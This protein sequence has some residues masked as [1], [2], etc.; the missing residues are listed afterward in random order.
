MTPG[1]KGCTYDEGC[2]PPISPYDETLDV[3]SDMQKVVALKFGPY[4]PAFGGKAMYAATRGHKKGA[5]GKQGIFRIWYDAPKFG[6]DAVSGPVRLPPKAVA[7][8]DAIIGFPPMTVNFNGMGSYDPNVV[9]QVASD[10]SYSSSGLQYKWDFGSGG[11]SQAYT[12]KASYRYE[13]AG[14]Y[15]AK[16]TVIDS[17]GKK[18]ST[19]IKIVVENIPPRLKIIEPAEDTTFSVGDVLKLR[20]SAT[21]FDEKKKISDDNLL[22]EVRLHHR[23][24]FHTMLEPTRG[25]KI[26]LPPAPEPSNFATAQESYLVVLLTARD[27]NG[28]SA[29][30]ETIIR[31]KL[32]EFTLNTNP[33]GMMLM[34]NSETFKTPITLSTWNKNKVK[35][36]TEQTQSNGVEKFEF[37][38]WSDGYLERD[39]TFVAKVGKKEE[40]TMVANYLGGLRIDAPIDGST[41]AVGD[42]L[43]LSGTSTDGLLDESAFSWEV[44]MLSNTQSFTL[45]EPTTGNDIEVRCPDPLSF[46]FAEVAIVNVTLTMTDPD[47]K[48]S[49]RSSILYPKVVKLAF[50]TKPSG[51]TLDIN[52]DLYKTPKTIAT[53]ENHSFQVKAPSQRLPNSAGD[54]FVAYLWESWSDG[55]NQQHAVVTPTGDRQEIIASFQDLAMGEDMGTALTIKAVKTEKKVYVGEDLGVKT[56]IVMMA[57]AFFACLLIWVAKNDNFASIGGM[58]SALRASNR[59]DEGER[60]GG[61]EEDMLFTPICAGVLTDPS[62][63]HATGDMDQAEQGQVVLLTDPSEN[64]STS[65]MDQAEDGQAVVNATGD[66]DQAEEGQAVVLTDPSEMH[67]TDDMDQAEEGYEAID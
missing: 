11:D 63:I 36:G 42:K 51:L 59:P 44:K 26:E 4:A 50:D 27:E 57:V 10:G 6:S 23:D 15:Y 13:Q 55:G 32:V 65:D 54:G 38:K 34:A 48:R 14:I 61:S 5:E 18:D 37:E 45:L 2:D 17:D 9:D 28:L 33:S 41:F 24:H 3:F 20:G 58:R 62:E 60:R 8:A 64:H 66:M 29:T 43:R 16:L 7:N 25:N 49:S 35:I 52:G 40:S 46:E 21:S 56:S 22:W 31:P 47:G 19:E 67:A 53:W 39:R 30:T 12:S 1:G